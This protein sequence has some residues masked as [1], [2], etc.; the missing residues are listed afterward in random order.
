MRD[1]PTFG[2]ANSNTNTPP[3][4]CVQLSE[5]SIKFLAIVM[6][7]LNPVVRLAQS[8]HGHV[9]DVYAVEELNGA[10][11]AAAGPEGDDRCVGEVGAL[12]EANAV[13]VG[14][15]VREGDDRSVGDVA[16]AVEA[17]AASQ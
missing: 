2:R 10:E 6:S 17:N 8:G 15:A 14:A 3:A 5:D 9:G 13:E 4:G 12:E 7:E 1:R 16:A 11:V